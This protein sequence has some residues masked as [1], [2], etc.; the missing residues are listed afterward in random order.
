[1]ERENSGGFRISITERDGKTVRRVE[2]TS[3]FDKNKKPLRNSRSSRELRHSESN[4][5]FRDSRSYFEKYY[6]K[7]D[8]NKG[9]ENKTLFEGSLIID[10][11]KKDN[12]YVL[13]NNDE[14]VYV[15]TDIDRN[16]GLDGD[17]V[18]IK[19]I[20]NEGNEKTGKKYKIRNN[21]NRKLADNNNNFIVLKQVKLFLLKS[22]LSK[23]KKLV[24]K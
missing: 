21:Y 11:Y 15:K 20:K 3:S 10:D 8:V 7:D 16:R 18:V 19:I 14:K 6:T 1:M 4:S 9:L 13:I 23:I 22:H 2:S 24:E 17:K 5:R 12:S